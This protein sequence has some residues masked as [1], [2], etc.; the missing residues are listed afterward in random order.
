MHLYTCFVFFFPAPN[1]YIALTSDI[2]ASIGF[3]FCLTLVFAERSFFSLL[4]KLDCLCPLQQPNERAGFVFLMRT[5]SF[6]F[7]SINF[8]PTFNTKIEHT[9][10]K[11]NWK[12]DKY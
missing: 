5:T 7:L 11:K 1:P 3:L 10:T 8:K 6:C 2:F 4:F 9:K 12:V